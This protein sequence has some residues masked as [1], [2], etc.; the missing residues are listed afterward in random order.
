MSG[1]RRCNPDGNLL[2]A[3]GAP[4]SSPLQHLQLLIDKLPNAW[5]A[6]FRSAR[7][8][9]SSLLALKNLLDKGF[10]LEYSS[11]MSGSPGHCETWKRRGSMNEHTFQQRGLGLLIVCLLALSSQSA[12]AQV[13]FGSIVGNVTD[14]S[15]GGLSGAT[16]QIPPTHAINLLYTLPTQPRD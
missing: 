10:P 16:L 1:L 13:V 2:C 8:A 15:G 3:C 9:I 4:V 5:L 6:R 7:E 11:D 14:P 12:N